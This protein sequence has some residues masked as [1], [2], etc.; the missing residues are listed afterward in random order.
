MN[1]LILTA[2]SRVQTV[3]YFKRALAGRGRVIAT[4][5]SELAPALYAADGHHVV[6]LITAPDYLASILQICRDDEIAVVLSLLDPELSLLARHVE[7]FEVIGTQVMVSPSEVVERAFD[8]WAMYQWLAAEGL[9]TPRSWIDIQEVRADLREGSADFPLFVKSRTGSASAGIA[10]IDSLPQLESAMQATPD[11]L[12]QEF[13]PG[14]PVD[15][16]VYVDLMS[17]EV[18][19]MFAKKKLRMRAGTADK[20][21]SFKDDSLFQLVSDFAARA[22]FRG[23]IDVDLFSTDDGWSI[24]EVNPRFG[25][26]YPHAYECGVDFPSM[27]LR[28]VA[29]VANERS[30]GDYE[31]DWAMLAYDGVL[32]QRID[33]LSKH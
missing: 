17:G 30:I 13:L 22:G 19:S 24:L 29:G 18:V 5:A 25:G 9:P 3:T 2:G 31:E 21:V 16:D 32:M 1:V 7:E 10:K 12:I 11:L 27:L 26:V 20:S 6:P 15:V 28:N 4:D 33:G 14:D 23:A 8:K